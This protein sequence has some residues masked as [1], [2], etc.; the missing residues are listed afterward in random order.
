MKLH[1]LVEQYIAYR[2]ALGDRFLSDARC[3]RGFVRAIGL[4]ATVSAVRPKQ[5]EAFLVGDGTITSS[6]HI[7]HNTLLGFYRY[8]I[9][10]GYVAKSPLPPVLPKRPPA[11]VPYIYTNDEV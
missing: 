4:R 1:E 10:R 5:V 8:A 11:F 3:L 2:Q 9:S 6:W 7:K